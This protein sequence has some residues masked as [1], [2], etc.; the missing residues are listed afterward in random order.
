MRAKV[1]DSAGLKEGSFRDSSDQAKQK[2]AGE[3]GFGSQRS[4]EVKT[5]DG[6]AIACFVRCSLLTMSGC[7]ST[8]NVSLSVS[9]MGAHHRSNEKKKKKSSMQ[10]TTEM[11]LDDLLEAS[12][13]F[14]DVSARRLI[15][16][17]E[18][19]EV[20]SGVELGRGEFGVVSEVSTLCLDETCD[21]Q[22]PIARGSVPLES[23]LPVHDATEG[24][25]KEND[26]EEPP[27][28][29]SFVEE[30][31]VANTEITSLFDGRLCC[32]EEDCHAKEDEVEEE[33]EEEVLLAKNNTRI[34]M[35]ASTHRDG[36][37]RYAIKRLKT[38]VDEEIRLDAIIDLACE[39]ILQSIMHTNIIHLRGTVGVLGTPGFAIML[40]RLVMTLQDKI[41]EWRAGKKK[42][43][44]KIFGLVGRNSE[45]L[46]NLLIE[47]LLV[48]F[49]IAR[50]LRHLH[51]R[52]VLYYTKNS[53]E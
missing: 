29:I 15:P 43:Q 13:F 14:G 47:R 49:D 25:Q 7:K 53:V 33:D 39:A 17:F 32:Q 6:A 48:S 27:K 20:L 38:D 40:D 16:A 24:E 36:T 11:V 9:I 28:V 8:R 5:E 12:F 52:K 44:G 23:L 22:S 42:C 21:C 19:K 45:M 1:G 50:A 35:A 37:A 30:T 34:S 18:P 10:A 41:A 46:D 2:V 51:S 31:T 3:R 26:G 4:L